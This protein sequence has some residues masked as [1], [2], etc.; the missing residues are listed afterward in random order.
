M[1]KKLIL[2]IILF[3]PVVVS[4]QLATGS[5]RFYPAFGDTARVIETPRFVFTASSGSLYSYDKE[6]DETRVYEPGVDLGGFRVDDIYYDRDGKRLA[7]SYE[8]AC[9]DLVYDSGRRVNMPDIRDANINNLKRINDI[10]FDGELIYVATSFGLVVYSGDSHDVRESGIYD[11]ALTA[12]AFTPDHIVVI[13]SEGPLAWQLL[14]SPK[15]DR[16]N[17]FSSFTS[18][19]HLPGHIVDIHRVGV[20]ESGDG[21]DFML[22]DADGKSYRL[23]IDR[24]C[25]SMMMS[26]PFDSGVK[27]VS[28]VADG[29]YFVADGGLRRVF[30]PWRLETLASIPAPLDGCSIATLSGPSSVWAA[31][32][33]GLGNYKIDDGGGLTVLRD[34]YRPAEATTFSEI[35]RIF[36]SSD[37]RGFYV[38]NM[39]LSNHYPHGIGDFFVKVFNGNFVNVDEGRIENVEVDPESLTLKS[40]GVKD[41]PKNI[42][43]PTFVIEDPDDTSIRYVGSALDGIYVIKDGREIGKFDENSKIYKVNDWAWRANTA[44][45][46]DE[47]NL[48]VGAY[49]DDPGQ[50]AV[51]VLPADKRRKDPRTVVKD[52][53]ITLDLGEYIFERD[54]DF[55]LCKRSPVFFVTDAQYWKGFAALYHNGTL[56][57]TSDDRK[58]VILNMEDQDGKIFSPQHI[59]SF[60]EDLRGRVWVA[61]TSGV[62]EISNPV[63]VFSSDF[64]I[65]RLKIPRNDGS[66][67]ADY[68]LP[69]EHVRCIAVDA[70]NR[71]WIGT[72]DSGLFLVSE[73]G[74][75]IIANFN[76]DNSPLSTNTITSLYVDPNSNSVFVGTLNGLYEYSSTTAPARPD[77][78]DVYAYPNP[79][80]PDYTGWITIKG[81]MDSSLVK[82]VDAGMRLVYQ[83]ASQGG[84]AIWDGCNMNGARVKSG[85]YYVLA[86]TS[87]DS[88]SEGDVV[89]KIL[90]IN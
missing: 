4:A 49:T 50:P 70:A 81:L 88:S 9:I 29:L 82:I 30:S 66:N 78:S 58:V 61:T 68:L 63:S 83:T 25:L 80:S 47:G 85:V 15:G 18:L 17:L 72:V 35:S 46:D 65:N 1:P 5:W 23:T 16:H 20:T 28:T 76:T 12:V 10:K 45:I 26:G 69:T 48:I 84:M 62:F 89:T 41:L 43:S 40:S 90:V 37:G 24:G 67:L 51:S 64:R 2:L 56:S 19:G 75:E 55:L 39:S 21:Y 13:P 27:S 6:N 31:D 3:L 44:M 8:D 77:Y 14:V 36:P 74:D 54:V 7:V 87:G 79:V 86:S 59:N 34:R 32:I 38:S 53:W 57:D 60:V 11:T 52:D 42:Y 71:K 22:V 73:N 33:K